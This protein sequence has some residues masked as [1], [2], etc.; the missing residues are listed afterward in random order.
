MVREAQLCGQRGI[1]PLA[2]V[3]LP[4]VRQLALE[5]LTALGRTGSAAK[6]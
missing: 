3:L 6:L 1:H 4:A 5:V 2:V